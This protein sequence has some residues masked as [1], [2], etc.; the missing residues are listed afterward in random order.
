MAK[1]RRRS[2]GDSGMGE[3]HTKTSFI[4]FK[5]LPI[6]SVH[7]VQSLEKESASAKKVESNACPMVGLVTVS[8]RYVARRD[9]I[10]KKKK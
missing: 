9:P 3:A 7:A 1:G 2:E 5:L 8:A 6:H 10:Y 4:W